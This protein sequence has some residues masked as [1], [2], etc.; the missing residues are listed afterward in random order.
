MELKLKNFMKYSEFSHDF[1]DTLTVIGGVNGSGKSTLLDA[2]RIAVLGDTGRVKI[3]KSLKELISDSKSNG[4]IAFDGNVVDLKTGRLAKGELRSHYRYCLSPELIIADSAKDVRDW[5]MRVGNGLLSMDELTDAFAKR[6]ASD[7][8]I[9]LL[10]D[11]SSPSGASAKINEEASY[12]RRK[13]REI[14]GQQYGEQKAQYW[15]PAKSTRP[16]VD[17]DALREGIE[18][19]KLLSCS[20]SDE[21]AKSS[22]KQNILNKVATDDQINKWK[23]EVARYDALLSEMSGT[24]YQTCPYC[25]NPLEVVGGKI[26][27]AKNQGRILH[28]RKY[29]AEMIGESER[30]SQL[31]DELGEFR[32]PSVISEELNSVYKLLREAQETL[33]AAGTH[34]DASKVAKEAND[35]HMRVV[36]CMRAVETIDSLESAASE[37]ALKRV[38]AE[39]EYAARLIGL[40]TAPYMYTDMQ[41]FMGRH[42]SLLSN[43]EQWLARLCVAMASCSLIDGGFILMDNSDCLTSDARAKALEALSDYPYPSIIAGV[44]NSKPDFG[45]YLLWL[46]TAKQ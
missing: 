33:I 25:N 43:G 26:V 22:Q 27:E 15:E 46:E 19:L 40:S 2:I 9:D 18:E 20:L 23:E 10:N 37:Q 38:N 39:L 34:K 32:N 31:A 41:L 21:L 11:A 13:W 28:K 24:V 30:M 42:Y 14:T 35:C 16:D 29:Y 44:Y 4:S 12:F 7:W 5:V 17:T 36:E 45:D 3:K 6:N 1:G 8:L